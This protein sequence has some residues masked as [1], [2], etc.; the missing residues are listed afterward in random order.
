MVFLF[1]VVGFKIVFIIILK[2][3]GRWSEYGKV[4]MGVYKLYVEVERFV[5]I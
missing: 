2:V 5:F 3:L 4:W 1:V